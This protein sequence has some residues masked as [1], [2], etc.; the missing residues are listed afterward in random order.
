[1]DFFAFDDEYV[2]RL[3]EGD[4]KTVEHYH[5]YFG[6]FLRRKLYGRIPSGDVDDIIQEVHY[7]VFTHLASGKPIH[8]SRRFGSFVFGFCDNIVRE[9]G[10]ANKETVELDDQL[11]TDI[12]LL[13]DLITAETK[14]RVADVV[15]S[16]DARDAEI[17]RAVFL[18]EV[19]RDEI[20]RDLQ[21][22]R[23]YLRVLIHRA[24][25]RFRDKYDDS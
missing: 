6:F 4:R 3:R 11:A 23:N 22:D 7:R 25:E 8:D 19:D 13:R 2:R 1:M 16:L 15:A 14:K 18:N 5:K 20:C 9:R 17:L 10:R 12:D 24:L 21:V